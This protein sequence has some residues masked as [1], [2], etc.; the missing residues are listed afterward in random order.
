M[1]IQN[2][3]SL[4][5]RLERV[6]IENI[7]QAENELQD[8]RQQKLTTTS[9]KQESADLI[10]NGSTFLYLT[11]SNLIN[12]KK[13]VKIADTKHN[14]TENLID[15]EVSVK[16]I[17]ELNDLGKLDNR[18]FILKFH[19]YFPSFAITLNK[20]ACAPLTY[21]EIEIC[22]YTKLIYSTKDIA[23]YRKCTVRSV[24]NRKH[25]IRKKLRLSPDID[26]VVWIASIK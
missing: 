2:R 16:E 6:H 10:L 8:V 26:F 5:S 11:V 17:N 18:S 1:E 19:E 21:S 15:R 12:R 23:L 24:D 14:K 13:E 3:I 22:A 25:R 7:G 4:K 20:T 9:G